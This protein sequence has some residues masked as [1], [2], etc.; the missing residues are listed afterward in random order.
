M[1]AHAAKLGALPS[2]FCFSRLPEDGFCCLVG[3]ASWA[4]RRHDIRVPKI[5]GDSLGD[6]VE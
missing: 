3:S 6:M 5:E 1:H 4:L 2:R